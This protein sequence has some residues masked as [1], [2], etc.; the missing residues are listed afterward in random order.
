MKID[1]LI[2]RLEQY[3]EEIGGECEVRLMT[4]KNWPLEKT[5]RGLASGLE[6]N[7][8]DGDAN[9][10]NDHVLY[11]IEEQSIR[12]GSRLAWDVAQ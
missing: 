7:K 12:Y 2:Q 4:Q 10:E 9:V 6:I 1:D 8:R 3:R 11:I 5:I